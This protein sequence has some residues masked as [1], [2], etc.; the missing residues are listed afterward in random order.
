MCELPLPPWR[1][2][3]SLFGQ[4]LEVLHKSD[5]WPS[6]ET[7]QRLWLVPNDIYITH[8]VVIKSNQNTFYGDN[9]DNVTVS[10]IP[11]TAR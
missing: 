9:R 5:L 10:I 3:N 4:H 11:M 1:R 6:A 7:K 2:R 8:K